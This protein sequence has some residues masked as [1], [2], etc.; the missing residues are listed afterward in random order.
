VTLYVP[1]SKNRSITIDYLRF[2]IKRELAE[3]ENIK[4]K[5]NR[6]IVIGNLQWILN[7]VVKL[8]KIPDNGVVF[9]YG[10]GKYEDEVLEIRDMIVPHLP[11][12]NSEYYCGKEFLVEKLEEMIVPSAQ[13]VVVLLEGGKLAWGVLKGSHLEVKH[14][15]SYHVPGKTRKGGMSAKRYGKL[16]Q[17]KLVK[18]YKEVAIHLNKELLDN[19]DDIE[20]IIFGGNMIRVKE[21]IKT[22]YL[23]YRLRSK[24]HEVIM[25]ISLIDE[26]GL[27]QSK[28][29][30][31]KV[32]TDH[33]LA[34]EKNVW[35]EF[36][37]LL[38][39]NNP[40]AIYGRE[41]VYAA[42]LEGKVKTMLWFEGDSFDHPLEL[43][44][45]AFDIVYFSE[46]TEWGQQLKAF[47]G[48]AA[49]LRY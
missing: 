21:F 3:T 36:M 18:F 1:A 14:V 44:V 15:K 37:G 23:D 13:I 35:D 30:I 27:E 32:L 47:G 17:E 6:K 7:D 4:D 16:R 39:K 8:G 49:I 38:M 41:Q 25:P 20:M 46:D 2:F 24:I 40:K 28:K 34:E 26:T 5:A 42:I 9:F 10:V 31:A 22:K 45:G 12:S 11:I 48:F 43:M 33:I 29:E 19:I